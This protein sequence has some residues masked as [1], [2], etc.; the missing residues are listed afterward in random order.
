MEKIFHNTALPLTKSSSFTRSLSDLRV[1]PKIS[2]S[3]LFSSSCHSNFSTAQIIDPK[4]VIC[5]QSFEGKF[6]KSCIKLL[7]A[8][9]WEAPTNIRLDPVYS[10]I[11]LLLSDPFPSTH[12]FQWINFSNFR[13]LQAYTEKYACKQVSPF[14]IRR[15]ELATVKASHTHAHTQR[16]RRKSKVFNQS[17]NRNHFYHPFS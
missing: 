10:T 13:R 4:F 6:W 12:R 17:I 15:P 3:H 11:L 8:E 16:G 7:S 5:Q 9:G 2:C 14:T 1:L